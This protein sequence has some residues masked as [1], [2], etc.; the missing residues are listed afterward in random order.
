MATACDAHQALGLATRE[1]GE[2]AQAATHLH[3]AIDLATANGLI[4]RAVRA[5]TTLALVLFYLGETSQA[6]EQT[7][8]ATYS[9]R[10]AALGRVLHQR[11]LLLQRL[12]RPA[13]AHAC[14]RRA[15]R[16]FRRHRE[17]I[18]EAAVLL[19][20]GVMLADTGMPAAAAD[21]LRRVATISETL[22]QPGMAAKAWHN[23]GFVAARTGDFPRALAI[24]DG[25]EE[26]FV[27]LGLPRGRLQL[28]RCEVLLAVRLI[29]ESRQLAK[30]AAD[31]LTATGHA[32]EA[33]EALLLVSH[34]ALL[35]GEAD[36]ALATA[37]QARRA[38]R[39]QQRPGWQA[40]AQLAVARARWE[41]GDRSNAAL[42]ASRRARRQL[43]DVGLPVLALEAGLIAARVALEA[44]CPQIAT[45]ELQRASRARRQGPA[46]LRAQAWHAE[47]LLRLNRGER[48]SAFSALRAG[49]TVLRQAQAALGAIELRAHAAAHGEELARL[50]LQMA[51]D[52]GRPDQVL[53][54]AE[55]WRAEGLRTPP[56][57]PP[58][59]EALAVDL[60]E[61][62]RVATDLE[63]AA[64]NGD[65]TASLVNRQAA[66]ERTIARRARQAGGAFGATGA[67]ACSADR[68]RAALKG[69]ALL[70]LVQLGDVLWSVAVT[71]EAV[72]LRCLG[73]LSD[74]LSEVG[75]LRFAL[76]R[77]ATRRG[78][79]AARAASTAASVQ[80]ALHASSRL[81]DL[82]IGPS[83]DDIGDRS[84]VIVPT[85]EL[86]ALPWAALSSCRARP[87]TVAPSG[88]LWLAAEQRSSSVAAAPVVLVAGPGLPGADEEV[89]DLALLYAHDGPMT[90]SGADVASVMGALDGA[91]MAHIAAHGTYRADSPLFSSLRLSDG[92]LTVYDLEG[93][94]HP[95]LLLVL[96]AC[97][98]GVSA[99]RAGD[100]LMGLSS[101]LLGLGT[102]SVIA[103]ALVVP[104]S[105]TRPLMVEF[106][107]R[108]R[109]GDRPAVA[110]AAARAATDGS[111]A[112]APEAFAAAASFLCFGAG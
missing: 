52:A 20:R 9:A 41:R 31:D 70:E 72:R 51:I 19:N 10:G 54:W 33:S 93:L 29:P 84:L 75:N 80:S 87:F 25:V 12:G 56:V 96:S 26:R 101:A 79:P 15:L 28:D 76:R 59:N 62:R 43:D 48:R 78:S 97:D 112:D 53:R 98:S 102:R 65:S 50:G 17:A 106:H 18:G 45:R 104:D 73:P 24:Y 66:L 4:A 81:D 67:L 89:S 103:G 1:A 5:R 88:A 46:Q 36:V 14:Y 100:E 64:R 74:V 61:L 3:A 38:F 83:R 58:Q 39:R 49:L 77:M 91:R 57:R 35:D 55:Q 42:S 105:A 11:A 108:L 7:D 94:A 47:A 22:D 69:R 92:P 90:G 37:E 32:T 34:A 111:P 95:P 21:D 109:L 2:I 68:L 30:Q 13:E 16:I 107:R 44:G 99:V 8:L 110:L 6:L 63:D 40:Q 27:A 85:G 82:L 86:H 23:L 71:E 60:S